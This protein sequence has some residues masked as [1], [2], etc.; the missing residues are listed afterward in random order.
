MALIHETLYRTGKFS[1]VDMEIYLTTLIDQV[2]A[3]FRGKTGVDTVVF[4]RGVV[5]DLSRATTAGLIINELVTN[6]FKY[7]F[8]PPFNCAVVRGERCTIRITLSEE[9]G[10]FII[11]VADNG[12]GLPADLDP[13]A[14]KSLGLRLGEL[15]GPSP[16]PGG[17]RGQGKQRH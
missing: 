6:S 7:A 9:D 11:L 2:A 1:N 17:D 5:L 12:C 16:A 15:P 14:A 4:A 13:L 10:I 3:T 8:Q